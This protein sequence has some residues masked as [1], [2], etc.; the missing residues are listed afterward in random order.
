MPYLD[1]DFM[2][3]AMDVSPLDKVCDMT[4]K[5]DGVHPQ[6]EKYIL[7]K[8]FDRPEDPYLPDEV[9]GM[10]GGWAGVRLGAG[11]LGGHGC[12]RKES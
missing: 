6:M 11:W 7:R 2:N 9:R 5:P 1:R 4:K 10:R 8:A 3:Y 12:G